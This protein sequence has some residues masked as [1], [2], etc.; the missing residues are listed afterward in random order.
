MKR[1]RILFF[2]CGSILLLAF[3]KL[4]LANVLSLSGLRVA[5]L[6]ERVSSLGEENNLIREEIVK[7]S[8]LSRISQEAVN[9][10]LEKPTLVVNLTSGVPVALR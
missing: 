6:E 3:V 2:V 8:S 10:G 4:L 9:L 5:K 1:K 7:L